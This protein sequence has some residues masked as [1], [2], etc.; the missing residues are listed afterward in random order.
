[1]VRPLNGQKIRVGFTENHGMAAELCEFPPNGIEYSFLKASRIGSKIFKSPIKGYMSQFDVSNCDIVEAVLSPIHTKL[2]WLYSLACFQEAMAWNFLG[3]PLPRT[4]RCQYMKQLFLQPNFRRLLFWSNAGKETL[5]T[6]ANITDQ[7]IW[8]KSEVVYPAIR[9]VSNDLLNFNDVKV[10]L[11]FSGDFFRKGGV[12]VVDAFEKASMKYPSITLRVC[13]D[14]NIDFNTSMSTLRSTYLKKVK[15]NEKITFGRISRS[16][17]INNVLPNTDIYLLPTYNETFGFSL[18]EAMAFGIPVIATNH[19][20]IPEIIEEG[21]NGY[22]IDT[23]SYDC[24]ELF[25]GYIVNDIPSDFGNHV[26]NNLYNHLCTLIESAELR[27]KMGLAGIEI[28]R[29]KFSIEE[30]NK[31]MLTIYEEAL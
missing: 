21:V 8:E 14:E 20:A 5:K 23:S 16:E 29:S 18:L 25:K 30:R 10:N 24:E 19:M 9:S 28:V 1:M 7:R 15:S 17:M 6:Y 2:P 22:M 27:K 4:L 31:K 12:N 13:S 3:L 11:L 26:T